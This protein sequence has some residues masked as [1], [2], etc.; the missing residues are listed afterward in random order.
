MKKEEQMKILQELS[1]CPFAAC[2]EG[3]YQKRKEHSGMG[4]A[5]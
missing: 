4:S 2:L 3:G 5:R 1:Y